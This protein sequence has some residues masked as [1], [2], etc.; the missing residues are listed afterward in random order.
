M[1][2]TTETTKPET[3]ITDAAGKRWELV[4]TVAQFKPLEKLLGHH[5]RLL[6]TEPSHLV[7][8]L[9]DADLLVKVTH[10]LLP[11]VA[12]AIP[13]VPLDVFSAHLDADAL[14]QAAEAIIRLTC[15]FFAPRGRGGDVAEAIIGTLKRAGEKA[16]AV[17][18]EPI[19][20]EAVPAAA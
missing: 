4:L 9:A 11:P 14:D 20:T 10:A 17:E 6:V 7:T 16:A 13:Q 18:V 8:L 3:L 12:V 1:T 5:P 19:A 2:A 15:G